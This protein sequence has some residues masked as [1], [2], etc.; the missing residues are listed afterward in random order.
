MGGGV[1]KKG[2]IVREDEEVSICGKVH[3][4]VEIDSI[5]F[6]SVMEDFIVD[7]S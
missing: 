4:R 6:V 7:L 1:Q 5:C 2:T 3:K